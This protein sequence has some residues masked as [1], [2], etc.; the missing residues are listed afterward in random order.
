MQIDLGFL[1]EFVNRHDDIDVDDLIK[2][3]SDPFEFANDVLTQC[4]GDG[5]MVAADGEV[6]GGP[7]ATR[8]QAGMADPRLGRPGGEGIL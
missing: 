8:G 7:P 4:R 6:H 1:N 2:M 5:D 3:S